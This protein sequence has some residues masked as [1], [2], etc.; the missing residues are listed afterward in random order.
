MPA[1]GVAPGTRT[2]YAEQSGAGQQQGGSAHR[3]VSATSSN[4]RAA[5]LATSGY[6]HS[7]QGDAKID[8]QA[9]PKDHVM[10]RYSQMYTL[11]NI[12]NGTD[13]LTPNRPANIR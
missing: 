6:V 11:N 3:G 1:C 12:T 13:V 8:W 4:R 7:Y 5:E 9:S 10:G 2:P